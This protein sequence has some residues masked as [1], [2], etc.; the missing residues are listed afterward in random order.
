MDIVIIR[1]LVGE[2]RSV[3]LRLIGNGPDEESLRAHAA[4]LSRPDSVIFEGAINQDRIRSFYANADIFCLPSFAEG[5]PVVLMEAMAMQIACVSTSI[6]GVPELI[7][8]GIDGL[9][10]PPSDLDAL[11]GALARLMDDDELRE[12][13]AVRGRKRVLEHYD[14]RHN[15]EKLADVFA[16][17]VA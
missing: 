3:N 16:E 10:V 8:D 6:T 1:E 14:L 11:T 13:L 2:G 15:V 4:R 9:L 7:R 5:L 12:R 17:R